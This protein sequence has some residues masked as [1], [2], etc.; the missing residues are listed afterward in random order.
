MT[1][2]PA[3]EIVDCGVDYLTVSTADRFRGKRMVD[4]AVTLMRKEKL[5]GWTIR[6]WGLSGFEGFQV[7]SIQ[8]GTRDIESLV[9]ISGRVAHDHWTTF[10]DLS[11]NCSRIDLQVTARGS[12]SPRSVIAG[13]YRALRRHRRTLAKGSEITLVSSV[14]SGSTIYVGKRISDKFLRIYDKHAESGLDQWRDC[15]RYELELKNRE[16]LRRS[17]EVR[18]AEDPGTVTRD[19]IAG[20]LRDK[21]HAPR[22]APLVTA[23]SGWPERTDDC[24]RS[25]RY[26]ES[27]VAPM[28]QRLAASVG[29]P[30]VLEALGLCVI[31]GAAEFTSRQAL[32]ETISDEVM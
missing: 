9:R 13:C 23:S 1:A 19:Q 5:A 31:N 3:V 30:R 22:W 17:A 15:V 11:D 6:K 26:V 2:A 14:G 27:C 32:P 4:H 16:A 25:L 7:G 8:A 10:Y 24:A 21:G 20:Y 28:V 12:S 29:A 18:S